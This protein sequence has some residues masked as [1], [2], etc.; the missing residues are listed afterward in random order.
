ME[1]APVRTVLGEPVE[2]LTRC[3]VGLDPPPA[4]CYITIQQ[5]SSKGVG[6]DRCLVSPEARPRVVHAVT[7]GLGSATSPAGE[8]EPS[9]RAATRRP[10]C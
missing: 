6:G 2:T 4:A 10:P 5:G 1:P 7:Y 9:M 3:P 8:K